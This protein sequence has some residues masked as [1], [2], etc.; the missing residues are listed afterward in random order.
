MVELHKIPESVCDV[1]NVIKGLCC[2][3]ATLFST[4]F[5]LFWRKCTERG[6]IFFFISVQ[7]HRRASRWQRLS[8][9]KSWPWFCRSWPSSPRYRRSWCGRSFKLI[10]FTL[11]SRLVSSTFCSISS[12]KKYFH[13][14]HHYRLSY[15]FTDYFPHCHDVIPCRYSWIM[16]IIT[17]SFQN[18]NIFFDFEFPYFLIIKFRIIFT[19]IN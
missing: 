14:H 18:L 6:F 1:K 10:R 17:L 3:T 2:L 8:P 5:Y 11:G 16:S 13:W 4:N 9:W 7:E 15:Y 19:Y 12:K